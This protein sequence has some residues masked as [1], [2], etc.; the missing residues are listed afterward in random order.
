MY[1]ILVSHPQHRMRRE[2]QPTRVSYKIVTRLSYGKKK[3]MKLYMHKCPEI[4][5]AEGYDVW[6]PCH[7]YHFVERYR[8]SK[9]IFFSKKV[10]HK[11]QFTLVYCSFY[12]VE[13]KSSQF[14]NQQNANDKPCRVTSVSQLHHSV[15]ATCA[16]QIA[17]C[18]VHVVLIMRHVKKL[19]KCL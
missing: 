1:R 4:I 15:Q 9:V 12:N 13:R 10:F 2:R 11:T 14:L 5:K 3:S 6:T 8:S 19:L 17:G 16:V 18:S 7:H